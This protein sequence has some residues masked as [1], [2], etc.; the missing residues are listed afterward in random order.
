M[1]DHS[2]LFH[3]KA[4]LVTGASSGI[5]REICI[6]C[7]SAGASVILL[8]RDELR[9]NETLGMMK[10]GDHTIIS[11]DL[12]D[13]DFI[14]DT[15]KNI[16]PLDGVVHAAGLMKLMPL[17]FIDS[18]LIDE[19]TSVNLKA[20]ILLIST[21]QK[22]KK[23]RPASS[24]V[25]L[26]SVN[27]AVIGSPANSLYAATKGGLQGFCKSA[28]LELAKNGTRINCVAPAM[29]STEGTAGIEENV[30]AESIAADKKNYPLGRYGTPGDI[31]R[32]CMFFLSPVNSWITGTTMVID[33]G[34]T[35][36]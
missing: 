36:H 3:G 16:S 26:S 32:A 24:I 29:V 11:G 35:A 23:L 14:I 13:A 5:G 27:G 4:V 18:N 15:C 7:A 34:L 9:L 31:A 1:T 25:L 2:T 12:A 21:L 17:K 8:A 19:I 22:L 20:P 10:A 33:G 30:S 6:H 28:S